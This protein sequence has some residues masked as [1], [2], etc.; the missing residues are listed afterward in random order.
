MLSL[1]GC[2][3]E[4]EFSGKRRRSRE[5]ALLCTILRWR[6]SCDFCFNFWI[7]SNL[8]FTARMFRIDRWGTLGFCVSIHEFFKCLQ[9]IMW[10]IWRW[11][12]EKNQ[13]TWLLST[14]R[15]K[16][17]K[18]INVATK[19]RVFLSYTPHLSLAIRPTFSTEGIMLGTANLESEIYSMKNGTKVKFSSFSNHIV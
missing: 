18:W 2:T 12:Q 5:F 3:W 13:K 6:L 14:W 11:I 9:F 16:K 1:P 15:G 8:E 19:G 4:V 17:M 7:N 10:E